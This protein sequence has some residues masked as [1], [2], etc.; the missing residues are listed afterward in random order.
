MKKISI[1]IVLTLTAGL[2]SCELDTFNRATLT[3]EQ[4]LS[5]SLGFR[6]LVFS[7]YERTNDFTFYGQQAMMHPEVMADNLILV[8]TTRYAGQAANTVGNHMDRWGQDLGGGAT[9]S[10]GRYVTINECNTVIAKVGE[11]ATIPQPL[12]N[13]YRGEALFIRALNYLELHKVYS[14]EPGRE[15]NGFALGVVLR[16][17]PVSTVSGADLK[18]R[19]TNVAGYTLMESDLKEAITLL[20]NPSSA[21]ATMAPY[22]ATKQAAMALLAKVYLHWGKYTEAAL[23]ADQALAFSFGP[24]TTSANYVSAWT[25][26]PHPE[27][28]FESPVVPSDWTTVDGPNNSLHSMTMNLITS[29]QYAVAASNELIAAHETG[30]IRRTMYE[31]VAG[32]GPVGTLARHRS[33]KWSGGNPANAFLENIPIIRRAEV[34]LISAE[35]KARSG[36]E[37]GSRTIL[38]TLR[39]NRGLSAVSD[40]EQRY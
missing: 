8:S 33:K 35:G 27:S 20:P 19:S 24:L 32:S 3:P 38:N 6:S 10:D 39:A 36:D 15:V 34:M 11:V 40:T 22:R 13:R 14:Y 23:Y 7:A 21:T 30:D 28:F 12:K 26:N 5:D 17:E 9:L 31:N 37:A 29:A 25:L 18:E 16:T 4:S 1:L 2:I